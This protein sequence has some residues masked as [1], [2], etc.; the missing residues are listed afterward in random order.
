M[1]SDKMTSVESLIVVLPEEST[2]FA[3]VKE[4][5]LIG[6]SLFFPFLATL[7]KRLMYL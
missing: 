6:G 2:L 1:G 4:N 5:P 7:S 3:L